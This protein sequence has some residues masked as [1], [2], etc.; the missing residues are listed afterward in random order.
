MVRNCHAFAGDQTHQELRATLLSKHGGRDGP[1][2]WQTRHA[3]RTH[4]DAA[5]RQRHAQQR[6]HL[7]LAV[8][9]KTFPNIAAHQTFASVFEQGLRTHVRFEHTLGSCVH[10]Q[11]GLG[12]RIKQDTVSRLDVAQSQIV[13]LHGLLGFHQAALQFGQTFQV[14]A[15][16][17]Q[18]ASTERQDHILQ[19]HFVAQRGHVVH[20]P[21]AHDV[22]AALRLQHFLNLGPAFGGDGV[23]PAAA[24][25]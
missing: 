1:S 14:A 7:G 6:L 20:M 24:Q 18:L 15:H 4:F 13:A 17:Q 2:C 16:G 22:W 25:P 23:Q 5:R 9:F 21:P 3:G 19:S 8:A 11:Y 12:R 10:H